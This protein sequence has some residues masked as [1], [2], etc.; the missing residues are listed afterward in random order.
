MGRLALMSIKVVS[1]ATAHTRAT[2]VY[3]AVGSRAAVHDDLPG[4]IQQLLQ[5][6]AGQKIIALVRKG[7]KAL[8]DQLLQE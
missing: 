4:L 1:G 6:T 3:R 5:R 7:K 2:V 8:S